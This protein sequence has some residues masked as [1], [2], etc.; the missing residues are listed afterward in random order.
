MSPTATVEDVRDI[1]DTSVSDGDIQPMLARVSRE[2]GRE[3]SHAD[4][5][6][7]THRADLESAVAALCI[8]SSFDRR[9]SSV[10]LGNARKTYDT[11]PVDY[12]RGLV[13]RHDPGEAFSVGG[14]RRDSDRHVRAANGRMKP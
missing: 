1:L 8:V 6:D 10:K 12:F 13:R 14:V 4:F 11:N 3:Y 9:A 7:E 2:V 5:A